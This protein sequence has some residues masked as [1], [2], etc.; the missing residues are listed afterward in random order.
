MG[1]VIQ[2]QEAL[3]SLIDI[4]PEP[5]KRN[6]INHDL[7]LSYDIHNS[8]VSSAW[9][10]CSSLIS[11]SFDFLVAKDSVSVNTETKDYL[12]PYEKYV[13]VK[14]LLSLKEI[15]YLINEDDS[16][17]LNLSLLKNLEFKKT[18]K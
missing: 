7:K 15:S 3:G 12:N 2:F 8:S 13:D 16:L 9:F 17:Q 5:K 10:D 6:R 1:S 14:D 4:T 18:Q 11:K